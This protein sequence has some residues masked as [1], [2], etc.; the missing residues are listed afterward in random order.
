MQPFAIYTPTRILFGE[1]QLPEFAKHAA[2]LGRHAFLVMGGGSVERLGFLQPVVEQLE[3]QGVALTIFRGIEPNPEASTINRAAQELKKAGAD[4]IL[5]FGG[6]ST[7]DAAKAIAALVGSGQDDIWE[8]VG[9]SPRAGQLTSAIPIVAVPTT[10]ATASEVT[11]FAVVS[12]RVE[13]GKSVIAHEFLKPALAW[14]NPVFTQGLSATTTQDGAADIL[15]HVFENYLLGG[16]DSK[17]ADRYSE[18][19]M[20]TVLESLPIL[21]ADPQN[22]QARAD[23][24]WAATLALNE[25]QLAGRRPAEFVLHSIEHSLSAKNAELA[26]GRGLAT[27]YPAYFRWLIKSDRAVDR[28]AQLGQRLFGLSGS[29]AQQA[30]GFLDAFEGWLRD[31]GLLQ[32]LEQVGI[33]QGQFDEIAT[34]AVN[35]Y[36]DGKQLNALGALKPADIVE[37]F[38][39]TARQNELAT[40]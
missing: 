18:A 40:R 21:L 8:F 29:Q 15:S 1:S 20:S 3:A 30:Q 37:I 2:K 4:F 39:L 14:L 33:D 36:G 23:L 24:V 38:E 6:G 7:I 13:G 27:L 35:V 10:A 22:L 9:G 28:L 32:S 12:N 5:P 16:S 31:N 25:Y 19:V 34:Y 26:H 11:P 17:L